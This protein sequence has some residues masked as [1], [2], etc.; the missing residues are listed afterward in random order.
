MNFFPRLFK[1]KKKKNV[2]LAQISFN[3]DHEREFKYFVRYLS[4][5]WAIAFRNFWAG[6]FHGLGFLLGTA[7]FLSSLGF[8][9]NTVLGEIPFISDFSSALNLWLQETLKQA[10]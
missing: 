2:S 3:I 1:A 5:P 10:P 8:V 7:L 4:N 6:T 9:L